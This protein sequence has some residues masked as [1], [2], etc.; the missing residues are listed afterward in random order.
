MVITELAA[1]VVMLKHK[2]VFKWADI[3]HVF[4]KTL[5]DCFRYAIYTANSRHNPQL[6]ADTGKTVFP[7]KAFKEHV[8]MLIRVFS[9]LLI[10][11]VLL[12]PLKICFRIM[13]VNGLSHINRLDCMP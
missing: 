8:L 5:N 2:H 3:A 10:E 6:V 7:F 9:Q 12:N 1:S 13:C 4:F 11:L